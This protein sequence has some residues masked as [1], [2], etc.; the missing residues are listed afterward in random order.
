MGYFTL[1]SWSE[2]VM[3]CLPDSNRFLTMSWMCPPLLFSPSFISKGV[4][5]VRQ[6]PLPLR[7]MEFPPMTR[8]S[9]RLILHYNLHRLEILQSSTKVACIIWCACEISINESFNLLSFTI[10]L[11][12]KKKTSVS[13]LIHILFMSL[14]LWLRVTYSQWH[15]VLWTVPAKQNASPSLG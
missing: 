15:H 13:L 14:S 11:Q 10:S 8:V 7:A 5:T 3:D 2:L 4:L 12:I 6:I 9:V 1:F